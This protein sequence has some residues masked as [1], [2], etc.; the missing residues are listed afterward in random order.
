VGER[1]QGGGVGGEERMLEKPERPERLEML[2][3]L[4]MPERLTTKR[5]KVSKVKCNNFYFYKKLTKICIIWYCCR[6]SFG[7]TYIRKIK[8]S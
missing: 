8:N 7:D 5:A 3:K 2:E 4:E 1:V 6:T